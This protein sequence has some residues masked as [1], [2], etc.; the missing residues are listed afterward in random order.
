[1]LLES[2]GFQVVAVSRIEQLQTIDAPVQ[3]VVLC[4][5]LSATDCKRALSI[6]STRWP[7]TKELI[8]SPLSGTSACAADH[9]ES[10]PVAEGPEK[11]IALVHELVSAPATIADQAT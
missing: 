11:L 5:T 10:F 9:E 2:A 1:L 7:H 6:A 8:L 4:H 3:L